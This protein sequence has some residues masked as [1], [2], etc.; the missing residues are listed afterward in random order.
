MRQCNWIISTDGT[1]VGAPGVKENKQ[2]ENQA[3]TAQSAAKPIRVS[4]I[5]EQTSHH[6]PVSAFYVDCPEKGITARGYDQIAAK[7]TGTGVRITPGAH[8]L[9]I[10]VTLQKHN[11]EEYQ[12]THPAAH[13][14][15]LLKGALS[16]TVADLCYITCPKSKLK[17]ILHYMAEGWLGP[18]KNKV[19][20]VLF[21]YN[22]DNDKV[23]KPKD[24]PADDVLGRIEGNWQ[25]KVYYTPSK[26]PSVRPLPP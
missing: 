11:N 12:L 19:E 22:P 23:T 20:G 13:V 26:T 25:D 3:T 15:G 10:F 9:G 5:T 2:Q 8:N 14:G 24:V 1:P 21:R 4:Y 16:I 18:S 17:V 6:P 7:F